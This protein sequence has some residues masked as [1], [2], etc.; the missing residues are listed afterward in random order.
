[1]KIL[2]MSASFGRL[3][4][5][6]LELGPGMNVLQGEN[7]GGKST[8]AAFLRVML[9]GIDTRDRDRKDHIADK[10]RYRPWSGLPMEGVLDCEHQGRRI[11]L[12]RYTKG[13][14]PMGAFQAVYADTG[15]PVE[16]MTGDNCGE[17]LTGVGREVF[18]RS[19]FLRQSGIAV[20]QTPELERRIA[21]L[22]T[23]G[24]EVSFSQTE[25]RL[26]EWLRRRKYNNSGLIPKLE[27]EL[28]QVEN[29]LE[30]MDQATRRINLARGKL[31]H[32]ELEQADLEQELEIHRRLAQRELNRRYA[33]AKAEWESARERLTALEA[34]QKRFGILPE[35]DLLRRAQGELQYLKVLDE[36]IRQGERTLEEADRTYRE[37]GARAEDPRF[38]HMSGQEAVRQASEDLQ[39]CRAQAGLARRGRRLFA[40]LQGLGALLLA[41][42]AGLGLGLYGEVSPWLWIG[43]A[44]YGA[45]ALLS[46]L[47][48]RRARSAGTRREQLLARYG[49]E[50]EE[51]L[52][53]LAEEYRHREEEACRA[54]EEASRVR[55]S[56]ADRMARRENSW[57]DI[58]GFVHDF[59]PEVTDLF[60]CSAALSRALG[61]EEQRRLAQTRLEGARRLVE[62]LIAQGGQEYDT[63]EMLVPPTRSREEVATRLNMV[64]TERR[65]VSAELAMAT[66][67]Q[68]TLGDLAQLQAQQGALV[69]RLAQLRMEY[70]AIEE[71]LE[72]LNAAN[73]QLQ[74]RFSPELNA[75]AGQWMSRLT[76]GKYGQVTLDRAL[77]AEAEEQ[78]GLMP[79]PLLALSQG[80]VDQLYLAVRLAICQLVLPKEE[81]CPLVLDD[82]LT[83]FDDR[84]MELALDC[85]EEL[86]R[87]RQVLLFTCQAREGR[88]LA[89]RE[90]VRVQPLQS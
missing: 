26:R 63:L 88:Y 20:G 52:T 4:R 10:N 2:R 37:A 83:N 81:P 73:S 33:G 30:R 50:E 14:N 8:W 16:G 54:M 7:E 76:G 47:P 23:T 19:A 46:L 82:A 67:E 11:N 31:D 69:D 42:F 15:E 84:R 49:A 36:E 3:E 51:Q 74:A 66:G 65:R 22:V 64:E 57:A 53:G 13:A 77:Q 12:R 40:L 21:A 87:Q 58:L 29:T 43:L 41:L 32:L 59:A 71:A 38:S 35:Q 5:A 72:A 39:T 56:L 68:Q 70:Q 17:L 89:G 28:Q 9:Y 24:E 78:D 34:E 85:L 80:T 62:E 60:G 25:G 75:L 86:S 90:G 48:L 61:L 44:S 18:E 1:M 6:V 55:T 45:L 27:R 79:R